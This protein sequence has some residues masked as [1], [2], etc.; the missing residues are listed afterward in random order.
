[1][2][3]KKAKII[4]INNVILIDNNIALYYIDIKK[5]NADSGRRYGYYKKRAEGKIKK[6][7]AEG[8]YTGVA[9]G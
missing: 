2:S 4:A 6:C 3:I 9:D 7:I 8:Q 1:L 5:R